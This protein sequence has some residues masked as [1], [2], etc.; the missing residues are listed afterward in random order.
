M[1][2]E[3]RLNILFTNNTL[4]IRGGS[5]MIILDL[6]KEFR[7]RGA[8]SGCLQYEARDDRERAQGGVHTCGVES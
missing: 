1:T 7:R 5:E 2:A 4:D 3:G 8:L 6:A